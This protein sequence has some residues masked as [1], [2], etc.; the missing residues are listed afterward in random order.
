[1]RKIKNGG[2]IIMKFSFNLKHI[3]SIKKY[4]FMFALI[5]YSFVFINTSKLS[6]LLYVSIN[7][8]YLVV[9]TLLYR[10]IDDI[11]IKTEKIV[12]SAKLNIIK[13]DVQTIQEDY[14]EMKNIALE[15][16]RYEYYWNTF[17][18]AVDKTENNEVLKEL[19]NKI[20]TQCNEDADK[21][22]KEKGI[23]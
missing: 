16:A 13:E 15:G 21:F 22:L 4:F 2:R 14:N 23:G 11:H 8:A 17:K 5:G 9:S 7:T 3:K 12:D 6:M 18:N 20:E 10:F 1:V 19:I